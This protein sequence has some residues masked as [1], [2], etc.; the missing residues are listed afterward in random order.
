MKAKC[1]ERCELGKACIVEYEISESE[2]P[3]DKRGFPLFR[4]CPYS[5]AE[6]QAVDLK[7]MESGLVINNS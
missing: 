7:D 6:G 3:L 1:V 5:E 4:F 2:Q